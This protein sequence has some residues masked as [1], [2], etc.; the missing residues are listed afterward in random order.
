MNGEQVQAGYSCS[1][2]Q[3]SGEPPA[4]RTILTPRRTPSHPLC[5]FAGSTD[6]SRRRDGEKP[7]WYLDWRHDTVHQLQEKNERLKSE[8][9]LGPWPRFNYDIDAGTLA[10]SEHG[11]ARVIAEIQIT[12]STS[13]KAG[14]WLWAWGNSHWPAERVVD[15]KL[16]RAFGEKHGID[17]LDHNCLD[18]NDLNALGWELSA[19]MVHLTSAVG[20]YRQPRDEGGGLYLTFKGVACAS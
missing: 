15:S 5:A 7:E 13:F 11:V 12:G 1:Q 14:N 18:A 3:H 19:V 6:T 16:V 17:E 4:R 9:R 2:E 10:F 8:F 20:A